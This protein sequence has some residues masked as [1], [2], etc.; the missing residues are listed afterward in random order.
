MITLPNISGAAA[1]VKVIAKGL[2]DCQASGAAHVNL[3]ESIA[4]KLKAGRAWLVADIS[5]G[6]IGD[7]PNYPSSSPNWFLSYKPD[8]YFNTSGAMNRLSISAAGLPN[9]T[10]QP[11]RVYYQI[12]EKWEGDKGVSVVHRGV[13][14][15]KAGTGVVISTP[16]A[17]DL[18][19]GEAW[20]QAVCSSGLIGEWIGMPV[21][22]PAFA[23]E[24]T[25]VTS[26]HTDGRILIHA[27]D[28]T[29]SKQLRDST[30]YWQIL[31]DN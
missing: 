5:S 7:W 9:L 4:T 19:N 30:V 22:S 11:A 13:Q 18:V 3:P 26:I 10:I 24:F 31:K 14:F 15:V 17:N 1:K 8:V 20:L 16:F 28:I 12:L 29:S 21:G 27:D 6:T 23:K 25:P 2:V